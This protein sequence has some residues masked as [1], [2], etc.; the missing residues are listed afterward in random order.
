MANFTFCETSWYLS[1]T[2]FLS[3]NSGSRYAR[4]SIK[5]YKDADFNLVL[6][7]TSARNMA[8]WLG[9]Q[10][11]VNS[12]KMRNMPWLWRHLQ[13]TQNPNGKKIFNL[14]LKTW[15]IRR[16][17]AGF[18]EGQ[19]PGKVLTARSPNRLAQ[20]RSVSNAHVATLQMHRSKTS[21]LI[22]FGSLHFRDNWWSPFTVVRMWLICSN[23]KLCHKKWS[24][25]Y[26]D[27]LH[28]NLFCHWL[29]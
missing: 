26:R 28:S 3:H 11:Q 23:R 8:Q 15:W 5:G 6:K 12:P 19:A 24:F 29:S 1:K 17:R 10:A 22:R 2:G 13:K 20:L 25:C 4:M 21:K 7:K 27:I 18:N 16:S 14:Q 9:A